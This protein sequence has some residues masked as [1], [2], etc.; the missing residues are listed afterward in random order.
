MAIGLLARSRAAAASGMMPTR[1]N[2]LDTV[3]YVLTA[4]TSHSSGERKLGHRL[5]WLGYGNSQ[6]A[7]HGRPRWTIGN[8]PAVSTPNTVSASAMR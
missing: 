5:R 2:T 7:N 8:R 3:R 6:Y 4:N 1:K